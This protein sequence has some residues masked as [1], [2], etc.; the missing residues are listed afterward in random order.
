MKLRIA[1][2]MDRGF[3]KRRA[4]EDKDKRVWWQVYTEDQLLRAERRL[5]KSWR[6]HCPLQVRDGVSFRWLTEDF[7]RANRVMSRRTRQHVIVEIER[8]RR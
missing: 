1:R 2:K 3:W 7:Y 4:L 6:T 8:G 5:R